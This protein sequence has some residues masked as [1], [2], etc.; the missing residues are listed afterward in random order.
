[1]GRSWLRR[2]NRLNGRVGG[3]SRRPH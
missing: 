1:M 2:Q 3:P